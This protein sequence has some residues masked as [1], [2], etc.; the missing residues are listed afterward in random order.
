MASLSSE[1]KRAAWKKIIYQ[2]QTSGKNISK[3]CRE[4]QVHPRVFY[5][6]RLKIFPK[7]LNRSCFTKLIDNKKSTGVAIEYQGVRICLDEHFDLTTLKNC[8]IAI[9]GIKCL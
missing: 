2:Q 7:V 5:S 4:N 3:W 8:L 6:W 1:E 9:R